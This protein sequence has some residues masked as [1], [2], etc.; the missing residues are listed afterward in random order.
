MLPRCLLLLYLCHGEET[1]LSKGRSPQ[2]LTAIRRWGWDWNPDLSGARTSGHWPLS[3][4]FSKAVFS[5][6]VL[7]SSFLQKQHN[8]VRGHMDGVNASLRTSSDSLVTPRLTLVE[9]DEIIKVRT[10]VTCSGLYW[11][12]IRTAARTVP[13]NNWIQF[14]SINLAGIIKLRSG[15]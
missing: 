13:Q 9:L 15:D 14:K 12:Q 3:D 5:S 4:A 6:S 2:R 1:K 10:H 11:W 7:Y 8:K